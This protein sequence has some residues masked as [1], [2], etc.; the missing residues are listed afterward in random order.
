[1]AYKLAGSVG[2]CAASVHSSVWTPP[3]RI[4]AVEFTLTPETAV[5]A[6]D[7]ARESERLPTALRVVKRTLVPLPTSATP[8][9]RRGS[10]N[11]GATRTTRSVELTTTRVYDAGR[12]AATVSSRSSPV[13]VCVATLD[14]EPAVSDTS[15]ETVALASRASQTLTARSACGSAREYVTF[16][17]HAVPAIPRLAGTPFDPITPGVTAFEITYVA[18]YSAAGTAAAGV[19]A[20]HSRLSQASVASKSTFART[21]A[22]ETRALVDPA[23][24]FATTYVAAGSRANVSATSATARVS[25]VNVSATPSMRARTAAPRV[26]WVVSIWTASALS[27]RPSGGTG[28]L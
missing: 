25:S 12:G 1:M 22:S 24:P 11:V 10:T 23:T 3:T 26:A 20:A 7:N 2:I 16:E 6:P 5:G 4:V 18:S 13:A 15:T 21:N 28:A 8:T 17:S 19:R 9:R 27:A 14:H